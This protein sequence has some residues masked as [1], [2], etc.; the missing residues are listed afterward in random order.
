VVLVDEALDLVCYGQLRQGRLDAAAAT[1]ERRLALLTQVPVDASSG[2]GHYDARHMA[3]Q[4]S[5]A[6]GQLDAARRH[7]D[8]IAQL[9]FFREERHIGLGRRLTVDAMAGDF[10]AALADADRFERDWLRTGRPVAGNLA[11]GAYS[12]AMVH[13]MLGDDA[14]RARWVEI[15]RGLVPVPANFDSPANT[16]RVVLD[17][18]LALHIGDLGTAGELLAAEPRHRGTGA[19]HELWLPW[20]AAAWAET[21]VRGGRPDIEER[22]D[23]AAAFVVDNPIAVAILDRCR[24]LAAGDGDRLDAIAATFRRLGCRYQEA[25]TVDLGQSAPTAPVKAKR[26]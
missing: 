15:T 16:W 3:C 10:D 7:A 25:R 11:V 17:A 20:Y 2:F 23:H 13:G 26:R 24:A 8:D 1:I 6:T 21:A 14:G 9:P 19:F 4:V 12:V 18:Y 5:L 22:L